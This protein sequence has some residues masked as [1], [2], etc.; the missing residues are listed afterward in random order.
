MEPLTQLDAA[1]RL[2]IAALVALGVGI[3][4]EWS[5]HAAGPHARFAGMRTFLLLGLVGGTAGLLVAQSEP[6][7]G[8]VIAAGGMALAVAAYIMVVRRPNAEIDGTTEAAAVV[9]VGLGVLAGTGWLGLAAGAGAI[10]VLALRE[11]TRLHWLVRR[12]DE[13]ELRAALQFAAM[14]LVVLPLLPAGPIWG[15]LAIRPRAL[16][17]VVLLFSGLNFAGFL[18][19][20]AVGPERGYGIAGALGGLISSTAVT[21][22]FARHS[23]AEPQFSRSLARGVVAACTVLV[24]RIL[25]LSAVLYAPVA[26]A[27]APLLVPQAIVGVAAVALL[28]HA[29]ESKSADVARAPSNPLRLGTAIRMAVAFQVALTVLGFAHEWW[30]ALGVYVSGALLGMTDMDALTYSMSRPGSDVAPELAARVIA[31]G[32]IANS[33]LKLG[34]SLV[35][36]SPEFRKAAALGLSA[37]AGAGALGLWL[38]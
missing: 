11:K 36:G 22:T 1:A 25:V 32:L 2:A 33:V 6:V 18:A 13:E 9:V 29:K 34:L 16:W 4:R 17:T 30:G 27:L 24:A 20:R 28:T 31:V 26:V 7:I 35:F 3:E 12:I 5:G 37:L 21:L 23:P 15:D 10:V 38:L 14:A 8:A 19:R